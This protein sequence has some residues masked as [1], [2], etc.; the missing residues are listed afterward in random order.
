MLGSASVATMLAE[1]T[2][3][4]VA[5]HPAWPAMLI[6]AA[7]GLA[8]LGSVTAYFG[9][10][11]LYRRQSGQG[12]IGRSWRDRLVPRRLAVDPK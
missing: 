5:G 4:D 8:A 12:G 6:L 1:A 2:V 7:A 10:R 3:A 11:L 9:L